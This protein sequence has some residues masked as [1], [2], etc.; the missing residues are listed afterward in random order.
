MNNTVVEKR[1]EQLYENRGEQKP[2]RADA[3]ARC[4]GGESTW[5]RSKRDRNRGGRRGEFDRIEVSPWQVINGT[6]LQC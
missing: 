6:L 3:P 5:I 2:W 1:A 4:D